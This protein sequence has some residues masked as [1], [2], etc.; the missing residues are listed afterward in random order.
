MVCKSS[1]SYPMYSL[2]QNPAR[3]SKALRDL[4]KPAALRVIHAPEQH[5]LTL[6]QKAQAGGKVR[7]TDM[8]RHS[9]VTH[10]NLVKPFIDRAFIDAGLLPE[11]RGATSSIHFAMFQLDDS[12]RSHDVFEC[13]IALKLANPQLVIRGSLADVGGVALIPWTKEW[14]II[15]RMRA[16]GIEIN[17]DSILLHG[18]EHRKIFIIDGNRAFLGGT[19]LAKPYYESRIPGGRMPEYHDAMVRLTGSAVRDLQ[20]GFMQS[21]L[22]HGG[23]FEQN[24]SAAAFTKRY[25]PDAGLDGMRKGSVALRLINSIPWGEEMGCTLRDVINLTERT[26][27]VMSPYLL[28]EEHIEDLCC[29][30]RRGVKIRICVP[31]LE[32]MDYK[33]AWYAFRRQYERLF[34]SGNVEI[35]EF[36]QYTHVKAVKSDERLLVLSTGNPEWN[37]WQ[38]ALDETL[39]VADKA[40]AD[41]LTACL[42]NIDMAPEWAVRITRQTC[43]KLTVWQKFMVFLS[44]LAFAIVLRPHRLRTAAPRRACPPVPVRT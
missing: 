35:F 13:F 22:L 17:F 6:C 39:V 18:L 8:V 11:L 23:R 33:L 4:L 43:P 2:A 15:G 12:R 37:S 38:R 24:L 30:A 10:D 44:Y 34:D 36:K 20:A 9:D 40:L 5:I 25:F 3:E 28:I 14:R 19:C 7:R 21:W 42:I 32:G 31:C 16:V 1:A 29:A 26:L 27:D 41:E